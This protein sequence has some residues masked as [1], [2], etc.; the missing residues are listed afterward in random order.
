MHGLDPVFQRLPYIVA[1]TY[2]RWWRSQLRLGKAS[3]YLST[4]DMMAVS[5][6]Q[7]VHVRQSSSMLYE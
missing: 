4:G 1:L 7:A 6:D 2:D 3:K 5:L